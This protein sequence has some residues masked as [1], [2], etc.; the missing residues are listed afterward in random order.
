[1]NTKQNLYSCTKVQIPKPEIYVVYTGERADK[2]DNISLSR[3][4]FGGE[5]VGIEVEARVIYES[6]DNSILNQYIKFTKV[7][8]E[9]RKKFGR[10][11]EAI[12]ETIRICKD[13]DILK[14][15]LESRESEVITIMMSLYDE[16]EVMRV[17]VESEKRKQ[18]E[19]MAMNMLSDGELPLETIARYSGLSLKDV[20]KLQSDMLQPV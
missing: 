2:P 7:Y 15:Y 20:K 10:K 19:D 11:Q 14:E 8:D 9:Q 3:E 16:E 17:Y 13:R 12:L 1:M 4:F 18:A 5:K 6:D